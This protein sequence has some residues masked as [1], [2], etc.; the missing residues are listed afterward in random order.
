MPRPLHSRYLELNPGID[1]RRDELLAEAQSLT[2]A[3]ASQTRGLDDTE[4][5]RFDEITTEVER[6]HADSDRYAALERH[7]D[8]G[9]VERHVNVNRVAGGKPHEVRDWSNGDELRQRALEAIAD[10]GDDVVDRLRGFVETDDPAELNAATDNARRVV[11][12]SD[13]AYARAF[14]KMLKNPQMGHASFTSDEWRAWER[15]TMVV[16][17]NANGGYMVPTHLDPTIILTN[18]GS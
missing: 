13:P 5:T 16:G 12:L 15:S 10:Q 11:A 6:I 9:H 17:T 4:A 2:D 8:A 1:R 14:G 18:N 3:A 7:V